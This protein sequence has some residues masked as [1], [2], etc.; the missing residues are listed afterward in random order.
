MPHKFVF[1]EYGAKAF[2][3]HFYYRLNRMDSAYFLFTLSGIPRIQVLHFY[4]LVDG[5]VRFRANISKITGEE[6]IPFTDGRTIHGKAWAELTGPVIRAP[7]IIKMKGFQG[8]RYTE[9]LF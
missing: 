8:F 1:E 4:L 2:L 6:T 7:F 9:E 5:R 3:D